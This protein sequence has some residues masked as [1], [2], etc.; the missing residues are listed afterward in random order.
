MRIFDSFGVCWALLVGDAISY[1]LAVIVLVA[2]LKI[3]PCTALYWLKALVSVGE[4]S[5]SEF[6][7]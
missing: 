6:C 4:L 3:S 2:R 1:Y 7:F 5:C